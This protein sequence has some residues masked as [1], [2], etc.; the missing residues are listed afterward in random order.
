[1]NQKQLDKMAHS[2][3]LVADRA[4]KRVDEWEEKNM[5]DM[6]R[7]DAEDYM[8]ISKLIKENK[9]YA[10][11]EAMLYLDTAA[12]DKIKTYVYNAVMKHY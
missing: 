3:T 11:A 2:M 6:F 8:S 4:L 12:R 10:A 5:K 1:M 7:K 9:L